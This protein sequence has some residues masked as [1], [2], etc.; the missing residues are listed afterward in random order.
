MSKRIEGESTMGTPQ[1]ADR[2]AAA[3]VPTRSLSLPNALPADYQPTPEGG[4]S[5]EAAAALAAAGKANQHSAEP[6]KTVSQ[7]VRW[8]GSKSVSARQPPRSGLRI[9]VFP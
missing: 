7:A 4:L 3:A 9:G 5:S 8:A 6:G 2:N 1:C